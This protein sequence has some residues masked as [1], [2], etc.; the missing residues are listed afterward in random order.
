MEITEKQIEKALNN[1]FQFG[2]D[3]TEELYNAIRAV[4]E[5]AYASLN[6][7]KTREYFTES[8]KKKLYKKIKSLI[9]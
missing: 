9:S 4:E 8:D 2:I 1:T 7:R 3:G 5:K 6:I